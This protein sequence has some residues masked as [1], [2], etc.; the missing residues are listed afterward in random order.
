MDSQQELRALAQNLDSISQRLKELVDY[1]TSEDVK[2]IF[3]N[4]DKTRLTIQELVSSLNE[5][6]FSLP[7][8]SKHKWELFVRLGFVIE[9]DSPGYVF[10]EE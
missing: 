5:Q 8:K 10:Y 7:K 2:L 9:K 3:Y 4:N 6:G 1:P